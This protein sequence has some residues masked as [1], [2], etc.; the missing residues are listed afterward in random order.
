MLDQ[1]DALR[2]LRELCGSFLDGRNG[3]NVT[4][5][6]T[7]DDRE[8]HLG[9]LGFR[10]EPFACDGKLLR[11]NRTDARQFV[12]GISQH[13]HERACRFLHS[14]AAVAFDRAGYG[15]RVLHG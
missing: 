11:E 7:D 1:E 5:F 4:Q 9:Q 13:M 15:S 6:R 2:R 14:D 10:V 8:R 12:G 3:V